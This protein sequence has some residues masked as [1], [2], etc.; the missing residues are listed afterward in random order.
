MAATLVLTAC[1]PTLFGTD[2]EDTGPDQA[3][4]AVSRIPTTTAVP[5]TT[6]TTAP[7]ASATP[8]APVNPA[9][10]A[11]PLAIEQRLAMLRFDVNAD[12]VFDD[13][14]RHAV[15]AFQKLYGLPRSGRPTPDVLV[16]LASAQLPPPLVPG[17]GPTRV[18]IDLNRQVIF[19]YLEG[20]LAR[21]LPT[22]TGSG[23]RFCSEGECGI[24]TTP[25]GTFRVERRIRGWRKSKL[26]RLY[27]PLY[28]NEGIA[29]HGFPSVP[30]TPASHGCVRIPMGA[31]EWFHLLVPDGTPVYVL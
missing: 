24:A 26:G 28:F 2:S 14:T 5:R 27:N 7:A 9:A 23:K 22:S 4:A 1:G 8:L 19:L 12:G 11:A 17:G 25:R 31:A 30:P 18:E 3:E 15:I 10:L 16:T 21:I 29:I 13:S 20:T 6:T